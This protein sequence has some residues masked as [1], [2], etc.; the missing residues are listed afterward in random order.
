MSLNDKR[1]MVLGGTSGLGLATAQAAARAGAAVTVVSSNPARVEAALVTLAR[2]GGTAP[3][4]GGTA[5]RDGGTAPRDGGTAPREGGTAPRDGGTAPRDGGTAPR[6]GGTASRARGRV[7]DL[8]REPAIRELFDQSEPFDHLVFTAG[9]PLQLVPLAQLDLAAARRFLE[10]RF[11]SALAAAK[12]AAP[13]LRAGGSIVL[14][15]GIAMLRPQAG[16]ALGAAVCGAVE[17]LTRALAVELAP[18]RVN[19]VMPGVVRTELWSNLSEADRAALYRDV[20]ARLP[21]GR[22]GEADEVAAAYLYF[23]ENGYTTGQSLVVDGGAV[24]V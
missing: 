11:F 24:L 3:R 16:W 7:A 8:G 2:H 6:H 5:P 4:E 17:S 15:S 20:G 23:T 12:Y 14:T 19:V 9:E 10:L 22:V 13:R 18:I 1:V 21:V